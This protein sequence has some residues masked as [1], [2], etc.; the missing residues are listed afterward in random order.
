MKK[1]IP[2][3]LI[4]NA[5]DVAFFFVEGKHKVKQ[6]PVYCVYYNS[7]E[8][9]VLYSAKNFVEVHGLNG[10]ESILKFTERALLDLT[11]LNGTD[12]KI[13]DIYN[14]FHKV[15]DLVLTQDMKK[16]KLGRL[17][18]PLI[19]AIEA[20]NEVKEQ[21]PNVIDISYEEDYEV[22]TNTNKKAVKKIKKPIVEYE[23]KQV[24]EIY[25]TQENN[26]GLQRKLKYD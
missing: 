2:S 1:Q 5:N 4:L 23:R 15:H 26:K 9:P 21:L 20:Y 16:P 3:T 12:S 17:K 13:S 25:N 11:V 8:K 18:R 19:D 7:K 14:I 10:K 22:V 6:G 24:K